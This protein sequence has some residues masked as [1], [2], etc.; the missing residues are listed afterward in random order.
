MLSDIRG[1][2][3]GSAALGLSQRAFRAASGRSP[4]KGGLCIRTTRSRCGST[5]CSTRGMRCP[6]SE[7][8]LLA[9]A[10]A[11]EWTWVELEAEGAGCGRGVRR[12]LINAQ[13]AV[14]ALYER[15]ASVVMRAT[16][17][18]R[19]YNN[20][21][22]ELAAS[23]V[24][25]GGRSGVSKTTRRDTAGNVTTRPRSDSAESKTPLARPARERRLLG[26]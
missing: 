9:I 24:I 11:L 14:A 22:Y 12:H 1:G 7:K 19:R 15:R 23:V 25:R 26:E 8:T 21:T 10:T 13:R 20:S 6:T 16:V 17:T 4:E 18:D 2:R 3:F 5:A